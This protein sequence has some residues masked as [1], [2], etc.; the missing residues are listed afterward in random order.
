MGVIGMISAVRIRE[1]RSGSVSYK[2]WDQRVA[3]SRLTR[4]TVL[5]P[6]L[7]VQIHL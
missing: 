1:E 7:R 6:V 3:S 4:D 2:T 5:C